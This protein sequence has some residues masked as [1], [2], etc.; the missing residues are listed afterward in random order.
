MNASCN[1][2]S[3]SNLLEDKRLL[4]NK[5]N[6]FVRGAGLLKTVLLEDT[7]TTD[8]VLMSS[9]KVGSVSAKESRR[10]SSK[11]RERSSSQAKRRSSKDQE[12]HVKNL[13]KAHQS[14]DNII[15]DHGKKMVVNNPEFAEVQAVK[16]TLAARKSEPALMRDSRVKVT[17]LDMD[18][19]EIYKEPPSR[20]TSVNKKQKTKLRTAT[21]KLQRLL[22]KPFDYDANLS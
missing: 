11:T 10:G 15:R 6:N 17:F 19:D 13:K 9:N 8:H 3:K 21:E 16:P 2:L 5:G 14:S 1:K 7:N 20:Q 18:V 22:L 12:S 4:K